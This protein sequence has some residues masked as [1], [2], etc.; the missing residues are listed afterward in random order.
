MEHL[1]LLALRQLLSGCTSN[2]GH[3]R[4]DGPTVK[5]SACAHP[6]SGRGK[7]AQ[8]THASTHT[9]TYGADHHPVTTSVEKIKTTA[10]VKA[11][12]LNGWQTRT[13]VCLCV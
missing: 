5:I 9:Q 10:T 3:L 8:A 2:L 13:G 1:K 7:E 6:G 12:M 4:P 11:F